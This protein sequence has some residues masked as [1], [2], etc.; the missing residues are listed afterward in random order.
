MWWNTNSAKAQKI[1]RTNDITNIDNFPHFYIF[2]EKSNSSGTFLKTRIHTL[3]RFRYTSVSQINNIEAFKNFCIFS[4]KTKAFLHHAVPL[5]CFKLVYDIR[6][7]LGSE[8]GHIIFTGSEGVLKLSYA[9]SE[10]PRRM[11]CFSKIF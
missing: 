11:F 7:D 6:E 2:C 3:L 9:R 8:S 4:Y 5:A 10:A 1:T